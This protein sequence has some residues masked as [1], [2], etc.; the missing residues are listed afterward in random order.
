VCKSLSS[1]S[2]TGAPITVVEA[3]HAASYHEICVEAIEA[4]VEAIIEAEEVVVQLET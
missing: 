1:L 2:K 4:A 3:C